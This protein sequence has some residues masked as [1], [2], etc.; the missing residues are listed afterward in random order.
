[1]FPPNQ[2]CLI[3]FKLH[4]TPSPMKTGEQWEK[5]EGCLCCAHKCANMCVC[6]C[7]CTGVI[8][9]LC[10]SSHEHGF[11]WEST[12][13]TQTQHEQ[14]EQML[15]QLTDI[16]IYI[17]IWKVL[18]TDSPVTLKISSTNR[19]NTHTH[20]KNKLQH[21]PLIFKTGIY[22]TYYQLNNKTDL[23]VTL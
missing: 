17:K 5:T 2:V 22:I 15:S 14:R 1:M 10:E 7:V 13:R 16:Y 9:S 6:V 3:L 18:V 8:H 4:L 20:K 19:Y 11:P 12:I 23:T 21:S